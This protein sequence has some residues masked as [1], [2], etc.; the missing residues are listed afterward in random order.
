[1]SLKNTSKVFLYQKHKE[2]REIREDQRYI[3]IYDILWTV[4]SQKI[5]QRIRLFQMLQSGSTNLL[6]EY[7]QKENI[8]NLEAAYSCDERFEVTK[9]F[10]SYIILKKRPREERKEFSETTISCHIGFILEKGMVR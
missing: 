10:F 4:K 2:K 3:A 6:D 1:M 7:D 9:V 5:D 8:S